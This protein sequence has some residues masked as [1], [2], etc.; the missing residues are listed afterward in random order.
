MSIN[1]Y[2]KTAGSKILTRVGNWVEEAA[3]LAE[4]GSSRRSEGL[5]NTLSRVQYHVDNKSDWETQASRTYSYDFGRKPKPERLEEETVGRSASASVIAAKKY[6][7]S[8]KEK[9]MNQHY[10]NVAKD[11]Y[12]QELFLQM[13]ENKEDIERSRFGHRKPL[14]RTRALQ[15]NVNDAN[16]NRT[17][18]HHLKEQA[19]S[20]YNYGKSG[21]QFVTGMTP[22]E[23]PFTRFHRSAKFSDK[24]LFY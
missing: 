7:G 20:I 17:P 14:N 22:A 2:N 24:H 21:D 10:M 6:N 11:L 5:E 12:Q 19:I 13:K 18:A 15:T 23:A 8:R 3:L 16:I 4:T 9:A 1:D